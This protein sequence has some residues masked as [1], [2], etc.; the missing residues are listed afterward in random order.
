MNVV[1]D[2]GNVI[3]NW[4]PGQLVA[5]LFP[6]ADEQQA[7]LEEVIQQEDWLDLDRGRLDLDAAIDRACS[8]SGLPRPQVAALYQAVPQH[9]TPIPSMVA[10][11]EKWAAVGIPL[12]VLSNMHH[13]AWRELQD[14]HEFWRYFSGILVSCEVG[15]IK[16]EAEIFKLLCQ[17]FQLSPADTFFFDD[18]A[19]NVAAA[20]AF[21]LQAW[22][23]PEP[24]GAAALVDSV[25]DNRGVKP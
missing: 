25:L 22:R 20:Q 5:S 2:I 18:M 19:E 8:R 21:G 7:A 23:V 24:A 14:S 4:Q 12:Y 16:P 11:I 15:H 1:L 17:R 6:D 9:L 3:C 10:A 13:H